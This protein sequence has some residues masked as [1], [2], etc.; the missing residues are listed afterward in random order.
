MK[1]LP[2]FLIT[3]FIL[4]SCTEEETGTE[5]ASDT[6]VAVLEESGEAMVDDIIDII[7]SDGVESAFSFVEFMSESSEFGI[8]FRAD[9]EKA[10]ILQ[11]AQI[12]AQRPASRVSTEEPFTDFPTG[13]Y[14]WSEQEGD[15]VFT[16]ESNELILKF[17]VG[18]SDSNNG[19]FT[20]SK[21]EFVNDYLPSKI[22]ML[23]AVDGTPMVELDLVINWSA[24]GYPE[25]GELY[26]FVNPFTLDVNYNLTDGLGT[27][28]SVTLSKG[29]ELISAI[30]LS[31]PTTSV[32]EDFP[33]EIEGSV[34]Y[35][36]IKI[37]GN[38]NLERFEEAFAGETDP[39]AYMDVFF[40]ID[41]DKV[42][43]IVLILEEIEEGYDDYVPYIILNDGSEVALEE[44]LE[45]ILEEIEIELEEIF[46]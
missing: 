25:D 35:R 5:F 24:N 40:Y 26:L 31:T 3:L 17:P 20:L 18:E 33:S 8:G 12:F 6:V 34:Q 43:E 11:I 4:V 32:F 27:T 42:G 22:T 46:M 1:K 41:G 23:L 29:D 30:S 13:I 45:P 36:R 38:V 19:V 7:T 14:N 9:T 10:R 37:A 16:E 28:A 21:L 2:F 15:F 39:N 44:V